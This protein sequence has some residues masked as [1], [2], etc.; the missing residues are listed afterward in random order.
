MARKSFDVLL[1]AA[2]LLLALAC[3]LLLVGCGG[4]GDDEE[5][6]CEGARG[7]YIDEANRKIVCTKPSVKPPNTMCSAN[8][9]LCK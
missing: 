3:T 1:H 7:P 8:P 9:E 5:V 2:A 4:G 6:V